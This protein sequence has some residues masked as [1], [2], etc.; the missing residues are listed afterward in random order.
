[1]L[2]GLG[3]GYEYRRCL[4]TL[5][6]LLFGCRHRNLTFPHTVKR[7]E[8]RSCAASETGTYIVCID[9]GSEFAYSWER[10]KV[11]TPENAQSHALPSGSHFYWLNWLRR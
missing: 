9:C 6:D 11:V 3:T 7:G 1:M 5:F 8:R 4:A 2:F 10:M